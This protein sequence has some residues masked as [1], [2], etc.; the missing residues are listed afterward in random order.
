MDR[1][2]NLP[3]RA[4]HYEELAPPKLSPNRWTCPVP[5]T[6]MEVIDFSY[7]LAADLQILME[8]RHHGCVEPTNG[9]F[10]QTIPYVRETDLP[11]GFILELFRRIRLT[12]KLHDRSSNLICSSVR[13]GGI[14]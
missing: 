14:V 2:D 1:T 11:E 5:D 10:L 7:W 6:G 13:F 3:F 9:S 12:R 8:S 4:I